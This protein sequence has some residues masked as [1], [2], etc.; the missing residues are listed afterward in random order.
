MAF[1]FHTFFFF[2]SFVAFSHF[3]SQN[4][5]LSLII[6]KWMNNEWNLVRTFIIALCYHYACAFFARPSLCSYR[7]QSCVWLVASICAHIISQN[8]FSIDF[9]FSCQFKCETL[10]T[11]TS[12]ISYFLPI[13]LNH[14]ISTYDEYSNKSTQKPK[15]EF[16]PKTKTKTNFSGFRISH[17]SNRLTYSC[18]I[19]VFNLRRISNY[20]EKNSEKKKN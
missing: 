15:R 20:R 9:F 3:Y 2:L 10:Y 6:I 16:R 18:S 19:L 11:A 8:R 14:S 7:R 13:F 12:Q 17:N 4:G 1:N 5:T